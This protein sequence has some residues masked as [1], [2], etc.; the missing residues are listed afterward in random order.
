MY[1][2]AHEDR[3]S[4]LPDGDSTSGFI[5]VHH[6]P[7]EHAKQL[8]EILHSYIRDLKQESNCQLDCDKRLVTR[9][10]DLI[11]PAYSNDTEKSKELDKIIENIGVLHDKRHIEQ[12]EKIEHL[13]MEV[14]RLTRMMF[15][16][17]DE[18][19]VQLESSQ[20]NSMFSILPRG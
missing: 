16:N 1:S 9:I 7:L 18:Q 6:D 11:R 15:V 14:N 5:F 17:N 2:S 13:R 4:R 20:L 3:H 10:M 19:T 12:K 8:E